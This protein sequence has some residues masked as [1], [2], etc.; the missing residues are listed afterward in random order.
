MWVTAPRI[1]RVTSDY[2]EE[3]LV[4]YAGRVCDAAA[5][6]SFSRARGIVAWSAYSGKLEIKSMNYSDL[7]ES[8]AAVSRRC[9]DSPTNRYRELGILCTP[10]AVLILVLR[11]CHVTTV[12]VIY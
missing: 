7:S 6:E 1:T 5:A 9:Y 11:V 8:R 4:H 2:R 3:N 10:I 12:A